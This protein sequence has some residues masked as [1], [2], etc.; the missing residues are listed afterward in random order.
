M[1]FSFGCDD[2]SFTCFL[3]GGFVLEVN[4]R[5]NSE[6]LNAGLLLSSGTLDH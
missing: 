1:T 2:P 3:V 4:P 6:V 5:C